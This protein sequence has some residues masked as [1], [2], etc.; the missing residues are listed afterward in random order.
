MAE[1]AVEKVR[2]FNRTVTEVAGA[3]S[4]PYMG[5]SRPLGEARVLWEIG[6]AGCELATLR[7]RLG[8]DSGYLSRL[9]R[10]LEADQMIEVSTSPQDRRARVLQL[11][12]RG[13]RERKTL[14]KRSD[15]LAASLLEPLSETQR[16]RLLGAM[17]DVERLLAVASVTIVAV[18]P[19]HEDARSCL[20][21]YTVELNER[22]SRH[23]DP[24]VGAT[25]LPHE[26]RP[27]VG[28]FFVAYLRGAPIGCGAVKHPPGC[29]AEIKRMWIAPQARG[30]GLSRR[31]LH[32]LEAC[33][34]TAGAHVARI[35]TNSDLSEAL[36]LYASA[37]WAEV[38]PFNDEPFADRWLEKRLDD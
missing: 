17:G 22:S 3:L 31:L 8:L 30:L 27:P 28:E 9:L 4:D 34:L 12:V 7:E 20:Q 15:E 14:D 35:E 2:S 21:R 1:A 26:L 5:R 19:E 24:A 38:A 25:A 6:P 18:D 29:P 11:T 16:E 13:R 33:A 37:G 10:S 36:G 23:F 32:T